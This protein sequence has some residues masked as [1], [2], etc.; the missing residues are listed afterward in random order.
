[1]LSQIC[2]YIIFVANVGNLIGRSHPELPPLII[3]DGVMY[4]G[5]GRLALQEDIDQ[6]VY[7]GEIQNNVLS[8]E[9]PEKDFQTNREILVGSAVYQGG[10]HIIVYCELPKG[11]W[12][13]FSKLS[14]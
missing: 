11:S 6:C 1:M 3:V 2:N 4:K 13:E 10:E 12:W 7:L 8:Y 9:R 5:T 14:K